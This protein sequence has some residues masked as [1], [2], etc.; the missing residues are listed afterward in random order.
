MT[1]TV[2]KP[3][4]PEEWFLEREYESLRDEIKET[5]NR[6]FKTLTFGVTAIP[7]AQFL[8]ENYN[9]RLVAIALPLLVIVIALL[10]LSESHA[11]MRSGRYIRLNIEP[12][13]A[14]DAGW[15]RWLVSPDEF[16][17]RAPERYL[18]FSFYVL[19]LVYYAASAQFAVK[20]IAEALGPGA[21]IMS[22]IAYVTVG[23]S[24]VVFFLKK[25]LL[26][27]TTRAEMR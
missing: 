2:H 26:S 20:Q 24:S 10:Y 8:A 13:A 3:I 21:S 7:A 17:K 4:Q 9:I 11:L 27:T 15:E 19:F 16:S 23:I 14:G 5:K 6:L 1:S 22:I 25:L 12:R 18:A